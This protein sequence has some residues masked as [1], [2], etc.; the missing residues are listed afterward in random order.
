MKRTL[1]QLYS[2]C[3]TMRVAITIQILMSLSSV[4]LWYHRYGFYTDYNK[5]L[6]IRASLG[7]LRHFL[8]AISVQLLKLY[9]C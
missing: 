4:E 6:P 1:S 2:P 7:V 3:T 8:P 9:D 5:V